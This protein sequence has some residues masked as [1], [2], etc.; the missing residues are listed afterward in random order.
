MLSRAIMAFQEIDRKGMPFSL[1]LLVLPLC[2]HRETREVVRTKKKSYFLKIA[3]EHPEFQIGLARR[4]TDILPFT[5][6]GLGLLMQSGVLTVEAAGRLQIGAGIRKTLSGTHESLECQ[7][8]AAFLGKEFARIGDR[9]TVYAT[10]G[11]RP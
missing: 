3:A 6:E 1:S 4:C 9:S 7:R 2:L 8:T 11:V 5:F 10:L